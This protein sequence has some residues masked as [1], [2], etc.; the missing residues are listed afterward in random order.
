[1]LLFLIDVD[2]GCDWISNKIFYAHRSVGR[3]VDACNQ[4]S[5][6]HTSHIQICK[7]DKGKTFHLASRD[8]ELNLE[9]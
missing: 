9:H 2:F 7:L 5:W 8:F 6:H 1:M 4:H 3:D